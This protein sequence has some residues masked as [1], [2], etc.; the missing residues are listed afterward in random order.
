MSNTNEIASTTE[1][2]NKN[3]SALFKF[4]NLRS[5]EPPSPARIKVGFMEQDFSSLQ[6]SHFYSVINRD[7]GV[8]RKSARAAAAQTFTTP[9][10]NEQAK[11]ISP[12]LYGFSE[13]LMKNR[14]TAS[15]SELE[16]QVA[17]VTNSLTPAQQNTLWDNL[18]YQSITKKS[19]YIKETLI[20]ILIAHHVVN[21]LIKGI[22]SHNK[23]VANARIVLPAALFT[24]DETVKA[25]TSA[26]MVPGVKYPYPN[27]KAT[28]SL[29]AIT[30][31]EFANERYTTLKKE[32]DYLEKRYRRAYNNDYKAALNAYNAEIL[33]IIKDYDHAKATA[34]EEFCA[35]KGLDKKYDPADPCYQPKYIPFPEL[36]EFKFK[37]DPEVEYGSLKNELTPNSYNALL[38]AAGYKFKPGSTPN[39]EIILSNFETYNDLYEVV[40]SAVEENYKV[41]KNNAPKPT[42]V[43]QSGGIT[44][45][46]E[47]GSAPPKQNAYRFCFN[48]YGTT[49]RYNFPSHFFNNIIRITVKQFNANGTTQYY[50][51]TEATTGAWSLSNFFE[52]TFPTAD[53]TN[54]PVFDFDFYMANGDIIGIQEVPA[55]PVCHSGVY[56]EG[57]ST[58]TRSAATGTTPPQ[59]PGNGGSNGSGSNPDTTPAV[60]IPSGFGVKQLGIADY[61]KVEQSV[62]CYAE[63]EVSH[64]ENILAREYKEKSSRRLVRTE[65]TNTYTS[66]TEREKL[67]D[68]TSTDRYE[69]HSEIAR[70][71]QESK[72]L[73]GHVDSSYNYGNIFTVN[74]GVAFANNTSVDNSNSVAITQAREITERAMDRV[75]SRV[76]EERI[77]KITEEYEENNKHGFNNVEGSEHVV[78]VYHWVDKIYKNQVLN[79]G[80]RLMFEFMVPEP[81]RLHQLGMK[82]L[83]GNGAALL[84]FPE[85]P[86]D[87]KHESFTMPDYT[88]VSD[89]R[90]AYWAGVFNAEIE[91]RPETTISVGE[92]FSVKGEG[93][94]SDRVELGSGSGKIIIPDGYK[95]VSAFGVFNAVCDRDELGGKLMSLTVGNKTEAYAGRFYNA[96]LYL[97]TANQNPP[98]VEN[99][100]GYQYFGVSQFN[101]EVPVSYTLG[102]HVGGDITVSVK[103]TLTENAL[104]NWKQ[105]TFKSI[106]D[107]YYKALDEYEQKLAIQN[108][109]DEALKT[110]NPGFYR[111]MENLV[112]R[113]N[114]ISYLIDHNADAANTY[115]KV[116]HNEE[117]SFTGYEVNVNQGLSDYA[118]F[119]KFMEQAFEWSIMSYTFFP[120]YW[121]EKDSWAEKYQFNQSTDPL[122]RNFM[123]AGMAQVVVTVRPGFEEYV[124]HYMQTGEIWGGGQVPVI[125]DDNYMDIVEQVREIP[126]APIG[127]PWLTLLPTDLTILQAGSIGLVVEKALPCNC[128]DESDF[129]NPE[130]NVCSGFEQNNNQIGGPAPTGTPDPETE[131]PQ[132]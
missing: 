88:Y 3:A 80:R 114:C 106:M 76:K 41:I 132:P 37:V 91:A 111:Q 14:K 52:Y 120:Y 5:P 20:Q 38:Q 81:A 57:T 73:A 43:I 85:D 53:M 9:L 1:S 83:V 42:N 60:F 123:Q 55:I 87:V 129:E 112:L 24:K 122:F 65:E 78:G 96:T 75:I 27:D 70:A 95:A 50:D 130:A 84:K 97:D 102:N 32:L 58:P 17:M 98:G 90:A 19:V 69:M 44:F 125:G 54:G 26:I 47:D 51:L 89:I 39:P 10:T 74:A 115:G 86:R 64:I 119:A 66:E 107:A 13:W 21:K 94:F 31:A 105:Q 108:A 22:E 61:L 16:F 45:E 131:E 30:K 56:I 48:Q 92:S 121:A 128:D 124:Y 28:K 71:I 33:P 99:S 82:A 34:Q 117:N 4:V 11:L 46:T 104:N 15:N 40:N 77:R 110:I 63:G 126:T 7:P 36:P 2:N 109:K 118:S 100:H 29:N 35:V 103:C 18:Y 67:T 62:H 49:I 68:T 93:T 101:N 72:D 127:K 113:K 6:L 8:S 59:N 25:E 79:Y 23:L 12:Q 116:M